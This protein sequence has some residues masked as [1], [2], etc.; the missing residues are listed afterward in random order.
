MSVPQRLTGAVAGFGGARL[1]GGE[2]VGVGGGEFSQGGGET[3]G[4]RADRESKGFRVGGDF[5]E[6]GFEIVRFGINDQ[7]STLGSESVRQ[8][9]NKEREKGKEIWKKFGGGVEWVG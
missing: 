4:D 6:M 3:V 9:I 5:G 1:G 2:R 7:T 8:R